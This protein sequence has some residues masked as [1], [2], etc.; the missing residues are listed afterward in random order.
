MIWLLIISAIIAAVSALATGML[1][2]MLRRRA[3]LDHPNARSSHATPTP[4][5]GGLAVVPIALAAWIAG[6]GTELPIG[7]MVIL[8]GA[9]ALAVLSWIDDL[10]S[11]PAALRLA[12]QATVVGVGVNALGA[13]GQV[14]QGL[15]PAWLDAAASSRPFM[16][17]GMW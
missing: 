9:S 8:G 15:L 1:A 11:L 4:R 14:F 16:P 5:G 13:H 10:R 12:I 6:A 17:G 7:L 2:A 3:I